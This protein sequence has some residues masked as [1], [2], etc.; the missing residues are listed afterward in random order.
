MSVFIVTS[1]ALYSTKIVAVFDSRAKA[2]RF[3]KDEEAESKILSY[4]IQEVEV[5]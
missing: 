3:V 4:Q 5:K 1:K 2:E